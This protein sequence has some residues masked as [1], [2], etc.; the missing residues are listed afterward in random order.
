VEELC[1]DEWKSDML[2][3]ITQCNLLNAK[4][5]FEEHLCIGDYYRESE[6]VA[7]LGVGN[8]ADQLNLEGRVKRDDF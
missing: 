3:P 1:S 4:E 7:G 5:Y 6:Q 2:S 8:G